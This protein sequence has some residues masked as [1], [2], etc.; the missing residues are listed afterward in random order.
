MAGGTLGSHDTM[1]YPTLGHKKKGDIGII[2]GIKLPSCIGIVMFFLGDLLE[3]IQAVTFQNPLFGG[4]VN[5]PFEGLT[6]SL[7]IQ[8]RARGHA[9]VI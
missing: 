3:M 5:T 4:H 6:F 8:K 1:F 9:E 7:T 2:W